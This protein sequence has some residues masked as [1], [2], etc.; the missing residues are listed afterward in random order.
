MDAVEE[1]QSH[2]VFFDNFFTSYPLLA[3]LKIFDFR[4]SGNIKDNRL[5]KGPLTDKK[6]MNK[7]KRGTHSY[8]FD[9]N[10]KTLIVK[11]LDNTVVNVGKNYD[12]VELIHEVTY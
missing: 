6:T 10:E 9:T 4:A 11:W 12:A 8:S 7:Q 3:H 2:T 5:R 1:I